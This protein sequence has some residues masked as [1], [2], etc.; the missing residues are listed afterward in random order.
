[1]RNSLIAGLWLGLAGPAFADCR[2]ITFETQRFTLCHAVAGQDLR[3]FLADAE[4]QVY[5]AFGRIDTALAAEGRHLVFAMNAGMFHADRAPVGL[6]VEDGVERAGLVTREG[7]GNFGMLPNGVF[8]VAEGWFAVV[9]S[10]AFASR[11]PGCRYAT[12][13]G[14]MLVI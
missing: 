3:L 9:E 1:M 11:A 2:D 7:P 6:F 14:P 4:G 5:G 12:Q 8:C 13:S 10:R